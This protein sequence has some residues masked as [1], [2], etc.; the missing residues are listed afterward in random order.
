MHHIGIFINKNKVE[1]A[2]SSIREADPSVQRI[3]VNESNDGQLATPLLWPDKI[4][5]D[6]A[7]GFK[8]TDRVQPIV[9]SII[10][11]LENKHVVAIIAAAG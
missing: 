3:R 9:Y 2:H 5:F 1:I 8:I 10:R 6:G 4:D 11:R 7:D